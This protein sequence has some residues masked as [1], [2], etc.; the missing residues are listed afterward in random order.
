MD[1]SL[2][3]NKFLAPPAETAERQQSFSNTDLSA[4]RL[5]VCPSRLRGRRGLTQ[6]WDMGVDFN[7]KIAL[8][9]CEHDNSTN[10]S[11]KGVLVKFCVLVK[12]ED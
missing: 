6:K 7:M 4:V 9:A 8:F 2:Q 11:L 5:S 10:I 12:F 3:Q 1:G